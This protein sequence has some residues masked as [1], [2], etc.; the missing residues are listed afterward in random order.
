MKK[1]PKNS[2]YYSMLIKDVEIIF[3]LAAVQKNH[4]SMNIN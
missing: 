3:I 4:L 2:D 1:Q